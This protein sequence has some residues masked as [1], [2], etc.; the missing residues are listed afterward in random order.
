MKQMLIVYS[1]QGITFC[2][3]F[4]TIIAV[5]K[6]FGIQMPDDGCDAL[7]HMITIGTLDADFVGV[8]VVFK[9]FYPIGH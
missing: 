7:L 3:V 6:W 2:L 1:G 9:P 8:N 5:P 4:R